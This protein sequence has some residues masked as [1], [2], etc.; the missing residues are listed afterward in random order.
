MANTNCFKCNGTGEVSFKHIANGVC[1]QCSGSGKLSYRAQVAADPHPELLVP[2]EQRSTT[3]QWEYFGRLVQDDRKA[4]RIM[5]DAGA[6][7]ATQRY[8]TKAIMSKAI[9]M[10]VRA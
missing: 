6:P 1:F 7:M 10:A 2:A 8:V 3:K 4:C 9:E 5:K